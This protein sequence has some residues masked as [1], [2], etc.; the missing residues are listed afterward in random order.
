MRSFVFC[1]LLAL[2]ST[3][4]LGIGISPPH[5]IVDFEPGLEQEFKH[6]ALNNHDEP[7]DVFLNSTGS[8]SGYIEFQEQR[9][10]VPAT[11][12]KEFSYT[13][14]LP[15]DLPPGKN[16]AYISVLDVTERGGGFFSVRSSVE[17]AMVVMVPYP[18]RYAEIKLSVPDIKQGKP[19]YY[20]VLIENKGKE[21]IEDAKLTVT[22]QDVDGHDSYI[23]T[24]E[25]IDVDVRDAVNVEGYLDDLLDKGAYSATAV[26]EFGNTAQDGEDF[27]VGSYE[28][29]IVN[30]TRSIY[31]GQIY[32]MRITVR[33]NWNDLIEDVFATVELNGRVHRSL[34]KDFDDFK[35]SDL[36]AYVDDP[37]LSLGSHVANITVHY[38]TEQASKIVDL[39]VIEEPVKD[40]H[41]E[42]PTGSFAQLVGHPTTYLVLVVIFLIV[43]NLYLILRKRK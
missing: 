30:Y 4:A 23:K 38:G 7:I 6:Y 25:S 3:A 22:A 12:K 10:T 19:L 41:L 36:V 24:H 27:R 1:L 28:F 20:N 9:I 37:K 26:L 11:S 29:R 43:L 39:S 35:E 13:L 8:L 17:G 40:S 14:R 34:P 5:Y 16:K 32:P 21:P 33:S 15:E 31:H 18:G 2:F 42:S